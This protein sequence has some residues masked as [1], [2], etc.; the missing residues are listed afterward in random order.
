MVGYHYSI[1]QNDKAWCQ[2]VSFNK[3][4][5]LMMMIFSL[6]MFEKTDQV[7]FRYFLA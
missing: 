1:N 2:H 6:N 5:N 7:P 4:S 3:K